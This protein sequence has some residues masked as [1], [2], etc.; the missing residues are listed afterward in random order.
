MTTDYNLQCNKTKSKQKIDMTII[1]WEKNKRRNNSN[2]KIKRN[3]NESEIYLTYGQTYNRMVIFD[4][5]KN[6][7]IRTKLR[8]NM[9]SLE[10]TC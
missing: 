3:K 8:V 9:E 2:H 4:W 1:Y 7:Y 5:K 6:I 10:K